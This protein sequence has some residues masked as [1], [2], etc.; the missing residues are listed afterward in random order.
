MRMLV[1]VPPSDFKDDAL[2]L[3][4]LFMEKWGIGYDVSSY[5]TGECR[6]SQGHV[7]QV[8]LNAKDVDIA[9]YDGI[10][11][12]GGEGIDKYKLADFRPLSDLIIKFDKAGK[13]ICAIGNGIK[14]IP[15]AN[16]IK[17]KR[18]VS[19]QNNSIAQS[20]SLF[21]GIPSDSHFEVSGNV[22]TISDREVS[23]IEE[24]MQEFVS[25]LSA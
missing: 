4:L 23:H 10:I 1:F 24:G 16:I 9:R 22:V 7:R 19:N 14:V 2:K 13:R 18:V 17:G 21:H 15:R 8:S 25:R 5:H 3:A 20:V 6:G 11:I 12:I